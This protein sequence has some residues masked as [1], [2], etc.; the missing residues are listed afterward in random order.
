LIDIDS[1]AL[2]KEFLYSESGVDDCYQSLSI[3]RLGMAN[4]HE[5]ILCGGVPC[6]QNG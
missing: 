2:N 1:I 5:D 3:A 6:E 4:V